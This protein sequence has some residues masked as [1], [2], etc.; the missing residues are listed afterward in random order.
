[1]SMIFPQSSSNPSLMARE[2]A[3]VSQSRSLVSG[4]KDDHPLGG[5][6]GSWLAAQFALLHPSFSWPEGE[7]ACT[8][9]LAGFQHVDRLLAIAFRVA[10]LE[11]GHTQYRSPAG[12]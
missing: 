2:V 12:Q 3:T 9:I 8:H 10:P 7:A 5:Q 6:Q 1:M 11:W 4:V